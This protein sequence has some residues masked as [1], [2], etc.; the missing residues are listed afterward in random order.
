MLEPFTPASSPPA[1]TPCA[2]PGCSLGL[3]ETLPGQWEHLRPIEDGTGYRSLGPQCRVAS[4]EPIYA[5]PSACGCFEC[6][7]RL[8]SA[9]LPRPF[10]AATDRMVLCPECGNKRCPRAE[11]HRYRCTGSNEPGQPRVLALDEETLA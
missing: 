2:T 3:W 9:V 11:S 8:P 10:S 1:L 7:S 4:A 5:R 6:L